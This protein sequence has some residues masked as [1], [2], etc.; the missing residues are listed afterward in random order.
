MAERVGF[1]P[2]K[3]QWPLQLID[4]SLP[5][6]P[7]LP[8]LPLRIAH[9]CPRR[10]TMMTRTRSG[11]GGS[12]QCKNRIRASLLCAKNE[13]RKSRVGCPAYLRGESSVSRSV[14]PAL[15][16]TWCAA[17]GRPAVHIPASHR[18]KTIKAHVLLRYI[19]RK[20]FEVGAARE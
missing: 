15:P 13:P 17:E 5:G 18:S 3:S 19:I 8:A 10:L 12:L 6:L 7:S 14:R 16:T 20:G 4:S 9:H 2:L 11:P 1:E